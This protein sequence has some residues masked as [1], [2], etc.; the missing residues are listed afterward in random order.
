MQGLIS[1]WVILLK[2]RQTVENMT[3]LAEVITHFPVQLMWK[4]KNFADI[5]E[6]PKFIGLHGYIY[7]NRSF[8]S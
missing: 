8:H 4:I 2:D 7:C 3:S 1:F 5:S 6:I